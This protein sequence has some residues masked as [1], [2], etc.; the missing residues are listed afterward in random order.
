MSKGTER[1]F[2]RLT[3]A[4]HLL[5]APVFALAVTVPAMT[6]ELPTWSSYY[7]PSD[8]APAEWTPKLAERFPGCRAELPEGVIPGS[9]VWV[10]DGWP[11][12]VPFAKA[13]DLT[14]D[15]SERNHGTV[16]AECR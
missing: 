15:G 6:A 5:L 13:W 12:R 7:L 9:V 4:L 10:K 1:P 3:I 14:H 16:V 8:P 11:V 2:R